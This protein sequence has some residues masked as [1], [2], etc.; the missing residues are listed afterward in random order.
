[1]NFKIGCDEGYFTA[2]FVNR[3]EEIELTFPHNIIFSEELSIMNSFSNKNCLTILQD[4][5]PFGPKCSASM[6][7]T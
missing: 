3:Y 7:G 5:D 6:D 4:Q 1:M 2:K